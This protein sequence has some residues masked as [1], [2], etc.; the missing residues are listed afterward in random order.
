[1]IEIILL[2]AILLNPVT[3]YFSYRFFEKKEQL[4][5][6]ALLSKDA[7]DL[8]M[9]ETVPQSK[10]GTSVPPEPDLSPESAMDDETW[11]KKIIEGQKGKSN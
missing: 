6:R 3:A 9:L 11:F 1:M 10:L 7:K 5:I 8:K 2:I 4:Y